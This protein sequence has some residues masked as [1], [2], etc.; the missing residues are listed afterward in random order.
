MG[1][2]ALPEEDS[3][4]QST[5]ASQG[6]IDT[7]RD[8]N[9]GSVGS[10][11]AQSELN[12]EINVASHTKGLSAA[13]PESAA[14]LAHTGGSTA[15]P[16]GGIS[17][18]LTGGIS[19]GVPVVS[20]PLTTAPPS[21]NWGSASSYTP[22]ITPPTATVTQQEYGTGSSEPYHGH[23]STQQE[24]EPE[25]LS[26][27]AYTGQED[28]LDTRAAELEPS[29]YTTTQGTGDGAARSGLQDTAAEASE[30]DTAV[31]STYSGQTASAEYDT[32]VPSTY[33]GQTAPASE[34]GK[35]VPST[36]SAQD[37]GFGAP[38]QQT[39]TGQGFDS[40]SQG[41][42][43]EAPV[44]QTVTGQG[45]DSFSQGSGFEA[46]EAE[47]GEGVDSFA[48]SEQALPSIYT[49]QESVVSP[50]A[51]TT[52]QGSFGDDAF[53]QFSPFGQ[54]AKQQASPFE[55]QAEALPSGQVGFERQDEPF[56][57]SAQR[58]PGAQET[59]PQGIKV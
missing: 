50:S 38:A 51:Q 9:L 56:E 22:S 11:S 25:L 1:S 14:D 27:S 33:S 31:P 28:P 29:S 3:Y 21:A 53:A 44:Q 57:S 30:Y 49:A 37:S 16:T 59:V 6:S 35:S 45:F 48:Q 7:N 20:A 55:Q 47:V 58:A 17:E 4:Q 15:G 5:R 10:I 39:E 23:D 18:G 13:L 41:S 52:N 36:Y 43:F 54:K 12:N 42:G 26:Q 40:F 24:Y 2:G 19:E 32:A 46:Q 34:F 8:T